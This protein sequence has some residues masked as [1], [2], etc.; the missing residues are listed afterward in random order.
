MILYVSAGTDRE[1]FKRCQLEK[2]VT[3]GFQ[4]QKFNQLVI[5]GIAAHMKVSSIANIPFDPSYDKD[6]GEYKSEKGNIKYIALGNN[7]GRLHKIKNIFKLV[8]AGKDIISGNTVEGIVCDAINPLASLASFILSIKYKIRRIAIVTDI[9]WIMSEGN[10]IFFSILSTFLIKKYHGYVLLTEA[11]NEIVNPRQRPYII[12][13]GL[14]DIQEK[15]TIEN[16]VQVKK[17]KKPICVYTGSLFPGIGIENLIDAFSTIK[18]YE[19]HLYGAGPLVG[20]LENK[21]NI[22]YCG[23]VTNTVAVEKQK[24]ATLLINPRPISLGYAKYSFP[25]KMM[26]YMVSGTPVL[27]TKLPGIPKEYYEYV[28]L[29]DDSVEGLKKALE[30]VLSLSDDELTSKGDSAKSFVLEKKNNIS[31]AKNILKLIKD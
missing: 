6:I 16:T 1:Y 17:P 24:E 27:T 10:E 7:R 12:M 26:E 13:E 8:Q 3:G 11:M 23:A 19:L 4:A 14:C 22:K 20:K 25:S 21:K 18:G 30:A 5:E 28:F 9:P 31:Q 2:S 15:Q 29:T